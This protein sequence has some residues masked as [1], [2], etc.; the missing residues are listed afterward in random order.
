[1]KNDFINELDNR[2]AIT[3]LIKGTVGLLPGGSLISELLN[4]TIPNFKMQ[5]YENY[6]EIIKTKLSSIDI[7]LIKKKFND[8]KFANLFEE[9][10]W[11]A[12]KSISEEKRNYIANIITY[13][14]KTDNFDYEKERYYLSIINELND[15]QIIYLI[16]YAK[17][18]ID[19]GKMD[20]EFIEK[21][22]DIL[23]YETIYWN[24]TDEVRE[25]ANIIKYY[26][27]H[28]ERMGLLYAYYKMPSKNLSSDKDPEFDDKTGKLKSSGFKISKLGKELAE[29]MGFSDESKKANPL[30]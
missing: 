9:S 2:D 22:S 14:L 4:V 19:W 17:M 26:L 30:F 28:M 7:E 18:K 6:M 10:I 21:H 11:T 16:Y 12:T 13:S 20:K 15:I 23:K 3:S 8:E 27:E 1:M 5:Y 29:Y 24:S 25:K